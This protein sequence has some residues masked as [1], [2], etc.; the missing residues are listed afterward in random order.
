MQSKEHKVFG[1]KIICSVGLSFRFVL[2]SKH[3]LKLKIFFA[4]EGTRIT[5][6]K[7][8]RS[9]TKKICYFIYFG[10]SLVPPNWQFFFS[11]LTKSFYILKQYQN[12][13]L[14]NNNRKIKGNILYYK[15]KVYWEC[16][17]LAN[18]TRRSSTK[19]V[20]HKVRHSSQTQR[21]E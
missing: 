4:V 13:K 17:F 8:G 18:T 14:I 5:S 11:I 10:F 3:Y 15:L 12:G 20:Q 2:E 19:V 21:K 6:R 1:G 7:T 16:L 9:E